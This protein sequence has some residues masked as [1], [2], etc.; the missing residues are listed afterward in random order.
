MPLLASKSLKHFTRVHEKPEQQNP[1]EAEDHGQD[2]STHLQYQQKRV[3]NVWANQNSL[4][5]AVAHSMPIRTHSLWQLRIVCQ[6]ELTL[7]GSCAITNQNDIEGVPSV[8]Q[9]A[10]HPEH[11]WR[12]RVVKTAMRWSERWEY[13]TQQHRLYDCM[14]HCTIPSTTYP[15]VWFMIQRTSTEQR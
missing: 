14:E 13:N 12:V 6:S 4:S 1:N 2:T 11:T 5:L 7:F 10:L 9:P 15:L 8:S 3:W